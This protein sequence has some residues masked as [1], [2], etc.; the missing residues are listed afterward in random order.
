MQR[1]NELAC[2]PPQCGSISGQ[3]KTWVGWPPYSEIYFGEPVKQAVV[4]LNDIGGGENQVYTEFAEPDG[5]FTI[6]DI[7]DGQYMLSIFDENLDYII[8]YV[9]FQLP[10][11][12]TG[13]RD[14][15]LNVDGDVN[16]RTGAYPCRPLVR[17]AL[18]LRV[19]GQRPG[20]QPRSDPRRR[21]GQRH[22]GL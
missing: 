8:R 1:E 6:G 22:S 4:A 7:P 5:T 20:R 9:T 18:G 10:D 13:S 12:V 2:T 3:A 14:L 16:G 15:D 19:P 17:V 21:G 11:P